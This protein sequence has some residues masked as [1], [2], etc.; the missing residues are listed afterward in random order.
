MSPTETTKLRAKARSIASALTAHEVAALKD[1][2]ESGGTT[3]GSRFVR[4]HGLDVAYRLIHFGAAMTR[5]IGG[6]P[7][8]G[9]CLSRVGLEVLGYLPH[10]KVSG[11]RP[12]IPLRS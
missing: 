4:Q 2:P 1:L 8:P 5:P 3:L 12:A 10:E 6:Q 11:T 7:E 9:I